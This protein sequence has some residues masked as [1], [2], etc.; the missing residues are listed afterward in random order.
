MLTLLSALIAVLLSA[1][2]HAQT[3]FG[4]AT[5]SIFGE[6]FSLAF[7]H[8]GLVCEFKGR[9]ADAAPIFNHRLQ[10]NSNDVNAETHQE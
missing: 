4:G 7:F 9:R 6:L 10:M 5:T 3:S 2:V 1:L 8:L